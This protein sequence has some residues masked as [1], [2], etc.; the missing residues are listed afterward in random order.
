MNNEDESGF[1]TDEINFIATDNEY[2]RLWLNAAYFL[3]YND[4]SLGLINAKLQNYVRFIKSKEYREKFGSLKPKI[5]IGN[6]ID[7]SDKLKK[8]ANEVTKV[9]GI[10]IEFEK[11]KF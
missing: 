2:A 6:F 7:P 10:P 8:F 11:L 3:K 9:T 1:K 4:K 5:V